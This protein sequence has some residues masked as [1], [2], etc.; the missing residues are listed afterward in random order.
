MLDFPKHL[1][2]NSVNVE[3][4]SIE[5]LEERRLLSA[6]ASAVVRDGLLRV[7]GTDGNDVIRLSLNAADPTKLDAFVNDTTAP[8]GTFDLAQLTRGVRVDARDGNDDVRVDETNGAV[9]LA[10]AV[11]GGKG[12][13]TIVGGSGNDALS[14]DQG[15]D[16]INGGTGDDGIRG[17]ADDDDLNGAAGD[18]RVRGD[19]G[20]DKVNG[21]V[22]DDDLDGSAGDNSTDGGDGNDAVDGG[23]GH[24]R[25]HGGAGTDDF[26]R[27]DDPTEIDDQGTDDQHGGLDDGPGHDAT[28]DNGGTTG[29]AGQGAGD[30]ASHDAG[31]DHGSGGHGA[32][33]PAPA[34][35]PNSSTPSPTPAPVADDHVGSAGGQGA[36]DGAAHDATDDHGGAR[37]AAIVASPFQSVALTN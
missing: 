30:P 13:D 8:L 21:D 11:R 10:V 37:S 36:D 34:P 5:L 22:G 18:D 4:P 32:D 2:N 9:T 31:D 3:R 1:K 12:D 29:A 27:H 15:H 26:A 16:T 24:D 28:D 25:D 20:N 23:R 35:T 7:R 6:A 14:G 33:D 19:A 17:G